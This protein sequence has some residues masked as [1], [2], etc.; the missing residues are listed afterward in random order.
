MLGARGRGGG[1]GGL[2]NL[3]PN[4]SLLKRCPPAKTT[5]LNNVEST[6]ALSASLSHCPCPWRAKAA[7]LI[8]S[9]RDNCR[10]LSQ[11]ITCPYPCL[12]PA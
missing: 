1:L 3:T 4:F 7:C 11:W 12:D 6:F 9:A 10:P 2:T 8:R 5:E